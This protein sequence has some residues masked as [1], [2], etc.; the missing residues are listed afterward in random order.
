M[1]VSIPS[2]RGFDLDL[3]IEQYNR[4]GRGFEFDH[5]NPEHQLLALWLTEQD[6]WGNLYSRCSNASCHLDTILKV[7]EVFSGN[8]CPWALTSMQRYLEQHQSAQETP[9]SSA[10]ASSH[11]PELANE[12]QRASLQTQSRCPSNV[13]IHPSLTSVLK[14]LLV[15]IRGLIGADGQELLL[16]CQAYQVLATSPVL[17]GDPVERDSM[18]GEL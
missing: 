12:P 8:S 15:C 13:S 7:R 18:G 6:A 9:A 10:P 4:E 17:N 2:E 14:E 5:T 1:T 3:L 11:L 16:H